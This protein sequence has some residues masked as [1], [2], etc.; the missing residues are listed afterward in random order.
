LAAQRQIV[1][2]LPR[3]VALETS[4]F[5]KLPGQQHYD[6]AGLDAMW[7]ASLTLADDGVGQMFAA[8][9]GR[10]WP[11]PPDYYSPGR[12]PFPL[13]AYYQRYWQLPWQAVQ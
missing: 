12:Q 11:I 1:A 6:T 8:D 9:I 4:T 7:F 2:E 3:C 13:A 5:T 10:P